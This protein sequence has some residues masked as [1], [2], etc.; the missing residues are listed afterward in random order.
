[1]RSVSLRHLCV[2]RAAEAA[3]RDDWHMARGYL[4]RAMAEGENN[5]PIET[6]DELRRDSGFLA[7][8]ERAYGRYP[9]SS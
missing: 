5:A 4:R 8:V 1:M 9:K 7:A 6:E 3:D 2:Q